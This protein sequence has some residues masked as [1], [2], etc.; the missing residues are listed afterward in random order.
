MELNYPPNE[1]LAEI[2]AKV[3]SRRAVLPEEA[4]DPVITSQTGDPTGTGRGGS[5][6]PDL[7]AE[8]SAEPFVRGVIAGAGRKRKGISSRAAAASCS[9]MAA[10]SRRKNSERTRPKVM[11]PMP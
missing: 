3:A 4:E 6:K 9:M 1:A 5:D 7:R 2:Q 10:F 11:A 8:F